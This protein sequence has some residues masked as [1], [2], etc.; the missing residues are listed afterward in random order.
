MCRHELG[1]FAHI[2]KIRWDTSGERI[3][4]LFSDPGRRRIEKFCLPPD[5]DQYERVNQV[6]K[7]I[8]S[9]MEAA[10]AN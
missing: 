1:L 4:G 8:D 6:W 9:N 7:I 3:A 5:L 10:A 2:S